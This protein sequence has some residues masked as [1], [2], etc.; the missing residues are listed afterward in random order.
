MRFI[1]SE[2]RLFTFFPKSQELFDLQLEPERVAEQ[3]VDQEESDA[4]AIR[5]KEDKKLNIINKL[6]VFEGRDQQEAGVV[7]KMQED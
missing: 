5:M 3:Q 6:L 2:N 1:D 7:L 4:R